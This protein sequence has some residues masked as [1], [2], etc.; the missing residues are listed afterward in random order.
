M[1]NVHG[2]AK[3]AGNP[4]LTRPMRFFGINRILY[5]LR[6]YRAL[7]CVAVCAALVGS[8]FDIIMP[9]FQEY[10]I[11]TFIG[12]G[13]LNGFSFFV[14]AY[15]AAL[16]LQVLSNF[17]YA[18][19]AGYIEL[20]FNH[21]LRRD[22]FL[23]LQLLSFSYYNQNSS[24]YLHSRLMSDTSGIG[25][26]VVWSLTDAVWHLSYIIGAVAVMFSKNWRLALLVILVIPPAVLIV[27]FFER[28]LMHYN[29][30]VR[31]QNS[32]ITG[33]FSEGILG[34]KT[35][36]TLAIEDRITDEF[37]AETQKMKHISVTCM[38]FRGAF[39]SLISL[40]SSVT[41]AV[42]LWKG[43][44]MA[45]NGLHIGTL[46]AFMTYAVGIAEP[47]QWVAGAISDLIAAKVNI[48]RVT[49]LLATQPDVTDSPAVIEK[50]GDSIHPRTENWEK[51][52]GDVEFCDVTFRYPDGEENVLE[53][54]S[55]KVPFGTQVAIV[56]ETGAGK[57]TLVNLVCR[58]FEPTQGKILIDGRDIRE[59]SQLWMHR[60]IGYVL[61]TPHLFSGTVAENLRYGN[62]DATEE[63]LWEA[64]RQVGAA[65]LV[66]AMDHG[67]DSTVGEGGDMLS[68]GEKQLISFAR[69]ILAR[70]KIMVLDEATSSIDTL[71]EQKIRAAME[72]VLRGRTSFV[73]A[74][75]LSTVR[76]ADVILVVRDG[77][78]VEQG[79]HAQLMQCRGYYYE[80]QRNQYHEEASAAVF[81]H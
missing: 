37:H 55:L 12:G 19:L 39:F 36:K 33:K 62:P 24:G 5:W 14:T 79:S 42:V 28:R 38:R 23:H 40:I 1:P 6:P 45:F 18:Y 11:N 81:R 17:V 30:A 41:L 58:F 60:N 75:R 27:I 29:R 49:G 15:A 64:L 71:T 66:E 51:L 73:I 3:N 74:H 22:C 69:A 26:T 4:A 35:V 70:P 9:L 47:V 65:D 68:T 13:T 53:H 46:S 21:D 52:Q 2:T 7:V 63:E 34:A 56:G 16:L 78:I 72:T 50:Y 8:V 32:V 20:H 44:I 67:L 48:E 10:A 59:R 61:Q 31:E 43:G 80:L 76:N 77:R 25:E 54:F 57:S